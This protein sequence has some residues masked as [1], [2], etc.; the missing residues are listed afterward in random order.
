MVQQ[1]KGKHMQYKI[2]TLIIL[3]LGIGFNS[4]STPGS[5]QTLQQPIIFGE[6]LPAS[7]PSSAPPLSSPPA[8]SLPQSSPYALPDSPLS[9]SAPS[10]PASETEYDYQ[11]PNPPSQA[12]NATPRSSSRDRFYFV[13]IPG[14]QKELSNMAAQLV[15][16]GV[17]PNG[18]RQRTVP[19]GPHV[20]IGPFDNRGLAE[21][22]SNYLQSQGMNARV[23]FG[24]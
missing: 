22:W 24:R 1:I 3:A 2:N 23:F 9:P 15:Q 5:A 16:L 6:E 12:N 11:A 18:V 20:A 17:A 7:S 8:S 4:I 19:R 21:Q 10:S 14:A 13:I